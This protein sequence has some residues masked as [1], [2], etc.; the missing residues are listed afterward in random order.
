MDNANIYTEDE[1]IVGL[2]TFMSSDIEVIGNIYSNPEL[3]KGTTD[4]DN[5]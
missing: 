5:I 1:L 4:E 2:Y 3:L